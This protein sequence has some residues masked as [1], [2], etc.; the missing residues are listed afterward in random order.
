MKKIT[1]TKKEFLAIGTGQQLFT[2]DVFDVALYNALLEIEADAE[3]AKYRAVLAERQAC[4]DLVESAGNEELAKLIL[5]R[6]D[7][8]K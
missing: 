5:N 4:A 2:K 8:S 6:A 3:K 1:K 7:L